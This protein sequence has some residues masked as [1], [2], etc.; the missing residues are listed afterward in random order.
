MHNSIFI[1][2]G[3]SGIGLDLAKL[4]LEEDNRVGICGRDLSKLPNGIME[5]YP[6]LKAYECDVTDKEKLSESILDFSKEGLDLVLANAGVS[7]GEKKDIPDFSGGRKLI[8]I[9]VQGVLNTFE[10]AI[11]IMLKNKKGHIAAVSSVAGFVGLPGGAFYCASKAA[12]TVLCESLGMDLKKYGIA[13]TCICPGFINTP[14]TDKNSHGMPWVMKSE[15]GA[16]KIKKALD[17][18]TKLF[19]FPWQMKILITYLNKMPRFCYR[20][21]MELPFLNY[22]K[23]KQ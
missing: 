15:K 19:I 21:I 9:N 14:L 11:D 5:K 16:R 7:L 18:K 6:N 8:D 22:T 10:P 2:G 17:K 23:Q 12:I 20:M 4:Y 3:T 1:T 13:V